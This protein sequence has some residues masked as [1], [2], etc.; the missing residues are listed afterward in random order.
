[1]RP[2]PYCAVLI[3]AAL[4]LALAAPAVS[5]EGQGRVRLGY[6][7]LEEDGNRSVY[8]EAY[9]IY[10]GGSV[11]FEDVWYTT[12]GGLRLRANLRNVSLENRNLTFSLDKSKK[13]SASFY[14]N[15][16]RRIYQAGGGGMKRESLGGRFSVS[17][18]GEIKL[19]AD[20]GLTNKRGETYT[21]YEP[22][23]D[24][25]IA[26]TDY[27]H[28]SFT[29]GAEGY[30]FG[31]NFL[32]E[33][34]AVDFR[35]RAREENDRTADV[36][37]L[38][39]TLPLPSY[40]NVIVSGGYNY[41]QDELEGTA[42]KLRTDMGWGAAKAY[43]P[44]EFLVDY[45]LVYAFTKHKGTG[46]GTESVFNTVA[47]SKTW[48]RRAGARLGYDN[49][50]TSDRVDRRSS[51]GVLFNGWYNHAGRVFLRA[52]GGV[53]RD[54][55]EKCA[56][57]IGDQDYTRYQM[58]AKYAGPKLGDLSLQYQSRDRKREEL[59]TR[60]DYDAFA[61]EYGA[62]RARYGRL[63][64]SYAYYLGKF[65]N[66][67]G[68]FGFS[69]HVVTA[70]V[71]PASFGDVTLSFGGVYFNSRR[72]LDIEKFGLDVGVVYALPRDFAVE[73]KYARYDYQDFQ[74]S[75]DEYA[76]DVVELYVVRDFNL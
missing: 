53:R 73:A 47:L 46:R 29:L 37:R 52:L 7:L 72:D 74:V 8:Q 40:E 64:L 28:G 34:Q 66:L 51:D 44:R 10:E 63:T 14:D 26:A 38:R 16:Y 21:V 69:D 9:N 59:G 25:A 71:L 1:M 23:T 60:V 15:K 50:W 11:S 43:L 45:R 65:Q 3:V 5:N 76:S 27:R 4:S 41:R 30:R 54:D 58:T 13:F 17:P 49:R 62:S 75:G 57:L 61:A 70:R 32:V 39:G 6:V 35:D 12:D 67:D 18:V 33:Y 20:F 36:L 68:S 2:T 48:E 24:P 42:V 19:Y 31:G 22:L 56:T 55:D